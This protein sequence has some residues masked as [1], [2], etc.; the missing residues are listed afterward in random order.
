MGIDAG[1][2]MV[3]RLSKGVVDIHNWGR[4]IESIKE[5]YK[6]DTQV[7]IKPNYISFKAGEHPQLP[8]EGHKF[9]RFS[10][11][12]SESTAADTKVNSYID[13]VTRIAQAHFASRIR[14]WQEGFDEFGTYDWKEVNESLKSYEQ[15]RSA[16]TESLLDEQ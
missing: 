1:F 5:R 14:C 8:F 15:V 16:C 7:E 2:D 12:I 9:L 10:P 11:K 3:P 13:T 6:D 4:F